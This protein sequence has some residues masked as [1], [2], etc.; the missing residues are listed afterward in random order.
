MAEENRKPQR[1][2][3]LALILGLVTIYILDSLFA[4]AAARYADPA[5]TG[6]FCYAADR[7]S[8][9][10]ACPVGYG[11]MT[12]LTIPPRSLRRMRIARRCPACSTAWRAKG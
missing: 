10:D 6:R 7:G 8:G 1:N 11:I 3:P 2:I 5:R 9:S 12:L 4:L